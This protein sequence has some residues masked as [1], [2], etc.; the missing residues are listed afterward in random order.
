MP[1]V[2]LAKAVHRGAIELRDAI[3]VEP[4][5][6]KAMAEVALTEGFELMWEFSEKPDMAEVV[7][8][9][10]DSKVSGMKTMVRLWVLKENN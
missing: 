2:V 8:L 7:R 10:R 9:A 1:F 5:H 4:A 3:D 6:M